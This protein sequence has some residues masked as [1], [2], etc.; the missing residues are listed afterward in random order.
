VISPQY[1]VW[2]LGLGSVCLVFSATGQRWVAL[3][4]FPVTALTALV[5]PALWNSLLHGHGLGR[6][7]AVLVLLLRNAAL[8]AATL[9]SALR[10]WRGTEARGL[11]RPAAGDADDGV[12][13]DMSQN[14]K[15]K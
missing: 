14:V 11:R 4:L 7:L 1:L 2:L 3:S 8:L 10:L 15:R 5:Y 6:A 9:Y 13:G 12:A